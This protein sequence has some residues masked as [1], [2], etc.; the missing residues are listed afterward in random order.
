MPTL[1]QTVEELTELVCEVVGR[2]PVEQYRLRAQGLLAR[3]YAR[4]LTRDGKH[5]VTGETPAEYRERI[6]KGGGAHPQTGETLDQYSAS[7]W[8]KSDHKPATKGQ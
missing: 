8:G 1:E 7:E 4:R 6:A 5:P 2:H 3:E